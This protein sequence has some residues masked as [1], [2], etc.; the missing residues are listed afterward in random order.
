MS[1]TELA[2]I[3][4][5]WLKAEQWEVFQEVS[6]SGGGS[7][8]CDIYARRGAVHWAIEV[9]TS[10]SLK[11]IEQAL[12]WK[13]RANR[14]SV[15]VP[16]RSKQGF[17]GIVCERFGIGILYIGPAGH[18]YTPIFETRGSF[19]RN[20]SIPPLH[21]EQKTYATAGNADSYFYT[22]FRATCDALRRAVEASPGLS[23]KE[24]MTR[25][26]HHYSSDATARGSLTQW[27]DQGKVR[28]VR[29][30]RAGR[31][32]YLF[33]AITESEPEPTHNFQYPQF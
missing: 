3:V 18:G 11:V 27:I 13:G 26:S 10:F 22:P 6:T 14:V 29:I 7:Q 5:N 32:V 12:K 19:D 31:R 30:E 8:R 9:K 2:A 16:N 25:I 15:A 23:M 17:P 33:P 24:A 4:V 21:E 20:I 1:E 28:G